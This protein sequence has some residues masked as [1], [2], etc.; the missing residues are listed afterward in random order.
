MR[1][2]RA[3]TGAAGRGFIDPLVLSRIDNLELLARTVMDGFLSGLHRSPHLGVSMEFAEHRP[4]MPGDDIRWIDWKLN[5]RTDRFYVKRFEADTNASTAILLDVSGSMGFGSGRTA[6]GEKRPDAGP[7]RSRPAAPLTKLDYGRY[8][9]ASLAYFSAQ[10]RDRVGLVTFD[11]A[12]REYV[13]P[14][15]KH[16]DM[17]LH[18]IATA[19]AEGE[20]GIRP[21]ILKVAEAMR[22]RGF[23]ILVSDLYED[24][25]EVVDAVSLLRY[26]GHEVIV[27]QVLDPAEVSFPYE[28]A[29]PFLDMET[30]ERL[31][32]VPET[33]APK[34]RAMMGEHLSALE[35]GFRSRDVDF[36]RF[37][38]DQPLDHA[39]FRYL[40]LRERMSRVR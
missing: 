35:D 40:S 27:F 1:Q 32:V 26:Q 18:R 9:T 15:A 34:Y 17:V 38:T 4:Y 29:A 30:G 31:P 6:E 33:L 20:S 13:P 37:T 24:P 36:A 12:V 25:T 22:K 16:L 10:Q 21:V 23:I 14:A 8:L 39:L 5:A 2:A 7:T 28:D 11:R 19:R 3:R